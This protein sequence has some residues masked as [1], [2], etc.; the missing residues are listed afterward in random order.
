MV[1]KTYNIGNFIYLKNLN[2]PYI[3]VNNID[4]TI[5]KTKIKGIIL[6]IRKSIK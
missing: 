5:D 6:E 1:N 2:I 3:I 4:K